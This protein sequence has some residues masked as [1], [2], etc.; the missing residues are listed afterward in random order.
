MDTQIE[1]ILQGARYKQLLESRIAGIREKYELRKVDIEVLYYLSRCGDRN[2]PTHI[3]EGGML[4]KSHIS[5]SVDVLQKRQLLELIPDSNDRRCIHL[6][7]T[8][9]AETVVKEI[10]EAWN[11]LNRMVLDGVTEEEKQ[12]FRGIAAKISANMD[13]ALRELQEKSL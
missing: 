1:R 11:D 3:R 9:Q 10:R 8:A 7:L 2:T 5:Q 4:T 12:V 6:T 13:R